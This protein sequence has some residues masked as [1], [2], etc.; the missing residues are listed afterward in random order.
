MSDLNDLADMRP[1]QVWEGIHV[2]RVQGD[3]LTLA[4]VELD[5]NAVVPEHR[6]PN[7]Q[8][9]MVI[10][11]QMD[12][13]VGEERRVLGP[14]GTWRIL[15]DVLHQAQ[16]GPNGAVVIDVFAPTRSDWDALPVLELAAP[17]WPARRATR[18]RNRDEG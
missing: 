1:I 5:P 2:R 6:H 16:A 7:E 13:Q 11:G 10:T 3:Q 15:G 14:G 12:F 17:R 8:N 9:G 18:M 4:I